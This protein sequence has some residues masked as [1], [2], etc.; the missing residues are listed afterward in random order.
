MTPLSKQTLTEH[1]GFAQYFNRFKLKN[2]PYCAYAPDEV[3]D[4]L[5]VLEECPIFVKLPRGEL[6]RPL[7]RRQKLP[8]VSH[9]LRW[10]ERFLSGNYEMNLS[11]LAKVQRGHRWLQRRRITRRQNLVE[12]PKSSFLTIEIFHGEFVKSLFG[13]T[14]EQM[15]QKNLSRLQENLHIDVI[16]RNGSIQYNITAAKRLA[17]LTSNLT[18]IIILIHG[19]MESSDGLMV[20]NL[21]PE[22]LKKPGL[23]KL[24]ALDG[25]KLITLEYFRSSTY[26]RFMGE[27]LGTLLADIVKMGTDA[28][29]LL[30]VGHSLGAH[31]AGFAGRRVAGLTR[32]R[33]GRIVALDPAGPCFT[34]APG[35]PGTPADRLTATDALRVDVVHTNGGILGLKEPVG[36]YDFFP[37]GGLTQPGCA[38]ALCD[39]SRAW[40]LYA[41]AV[42]DPRRFPERRRP[43]AS[44]A[45]LQL[46][47]AA[48]LFFWNEVPYRTL[49]SVLGGWEL[50]EK[51]CKSVTATLM[52]TALLCARVV[53]DSDIL[54]IIPSW[55]VRI[56]RCTCR[57]RLGH[58]KN[59]PVMGCP[60]S[61]VHVVF[62]SDIL[63]IIPSWAVRIPRCTC[64]VRLGHTKIIPSW[65]VRIPRFT[66]RVRLGH[67]KIIPSWAVRIPR[68]TRCVRLE[69]TKNLLNYNIG[70]AGNTNA[71]AASSKAAKR[72][73]G[74]P[75]A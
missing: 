59:N 3:K 28:N 23:S 26:A 72:Y 66:C 35:T 19:F 57:V 73:T 31:I 9:F 55:A 39:H 42:G 67:T 20:Q 36:H 45:A 2:S 7:K 6:P 58:T 43:F 69:Y 25:R 18:K 14:Y 34:G 11:I 46:H 12:R 50:Q 32:R 65:A 47:C 24:M 75:T 30:L 15:Q 49:H 16:N 27:K 29:R 71:L 21:A 41:E 17:R 51:K 1:G 5:H 44:G 70:F 52:L 22:L 68:C 63:K 61:Q 40:Q 33:V 4:L 56:P 60:Y 54:K 62:D 38:L 37:N 48:F 8:D 13:L 53:F 10:T 74:V 64:R